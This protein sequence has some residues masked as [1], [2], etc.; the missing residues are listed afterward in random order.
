MNSKDT[1]SI[2]ASG[3]TIHGTA[4]V[5]F[6]LEESMVIQNALGNDELQKFKELLGNRLIDLMNDLTMSL[7][8]ESA[9]R[10]FMSSAAAGARVGNGH[11]SL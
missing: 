6:G 2:T 5:T 1:S 7:Y 8:S 11:V 4:T 3:K 9:V 10:E